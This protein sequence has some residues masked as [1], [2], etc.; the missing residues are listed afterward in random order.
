MYECCWTNAT[1]SGKFVGA[2][3]LNSVLYTLRAE[4]MGQLL[5]RVCRDTRGIYLY[6][7]EIEADELLQRSDT[8]IIFKIRVEE[9]DELAITL[10]I[11]PCMLWKY[12][13][14]IP[15]KGE[16]LLLSETSVKNG[17]LLRLAGGQRTPVKILIPNGILPKNEAERT[18]MLSA[19]DNWAIKV[20]KE[21]LRRWIRRYFGEN[22]TGDPKMDLG[23]PDALCMDSVFRI[24]GTL[25]RL[26]EGDDSSDGKYKLYCG[27][28]SNEHMNCVETKEANRVESESNCLSWAPATSSFLNA[29]NMPFSASGILES[30]SRMSI[31][32]LLPMGL[33]PVSLIEI[34]KKR[35]I[36]GAS[37]TAF[38]LA[39]RMLNNDIKI[40]P[41]LLYSHY[42]LHVAL[43][44]AVPTTSSTSHYSHLAR[45]IDAECNN[46]SAI[47]N[48]AIKS[49][50]NDIAK[51]LTECGN[52]N[53]KACKI[54]TYRVLEKVQNS[55]LNMFEKCFKLQRGQISQLEAHVGTL[56]GMNVEDW[57]SNELTEILWGEGEIDLDWSI[58]GGRGDT[59][60]NKND[61]KEMIYMFLA[62]FTGNAS[63]AERIGN[64]FSNELTKEVM[65]QDTKPGNSKREREPSNGPRNV[66]P[67]LDLD[68]RSKL[69][70]HSILTSSPINTDKAVQQTLGIDLDSTEE[71]LSTTQM[72]QGT[73]HV[74]TGSGNDS[75]DILHIPDMSSLDLGSDHLDS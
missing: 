39:M 2:S 22:A 47:S 48:A 19:E 53:V 64:L 18:H 1:N 11:P 49:K 59:T 3:W 7:E 5:R 21:S 16:V 32:F 4:T 34:T 60:L 50:S 46:T 75:N 17:G 73:S 36:L 27:P 8:A 74:P 55:W 38:G 33:H 44:N 29:K 23:Y 14:F 56:N 28:Y 25:S 37:L 41:S 54:Y 6:L 9:W 62:S 72:L 43:D 71:L 31:Q 66:K 63:E 67:R 69:Q 68:S 35:E 20:N 51:L 30:K 40:K 57:L 10:N 12:L 70:K 15:S 52:A 42:L 26:A 45:S 24:I 13:R 61:W 65:N 58:F